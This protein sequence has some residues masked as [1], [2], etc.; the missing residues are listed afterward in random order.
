M[1]FQDPIILSRDISA[2]EIEADEGGNPRCGPIEQR[3]RGVEVVIIGD[4][5]NRRTI[6]VLFHDRSYFVFLED[7]E[8]PAP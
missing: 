3:P 2:I 7:I 1:F 8:E 4:G 6:R 5:F